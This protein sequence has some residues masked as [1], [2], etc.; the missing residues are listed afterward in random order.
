MHNIILSMPAGTPPAKL[1]AA[2]RVF[3]REQFALKHRYAMVLHTDQDHPH[4]HL[5][6]KA[7]D[8]LGERLNIRK[9]TLRAWRQE[10]ARHLVAQGVPANA[11]QRY[12][13]GNTKPTKSDGIYRAALRGES[14]HMCDRA[15]VVA[16]DL[17]KGGF[18]IEPGKIKLLKTRKD[19]ER[20]WSVVSG[21]LV[22]EGQT[23]LAAQV[24][25][26]AGQMPE[27][28]TEKE[29]LARALRRLDKDVP[30]RTLAPRL[31]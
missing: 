22:R 14:R 31:R 5:V 1:L 3:A 23:E 13:R 2:S 30:P 7:L 11:T 15:E 21:M 25:R 28:R 26:F 18:K 20:G 24:A 17:L 10:F 29:W 9:A 8:H 12:I 4:V 19:V 6:V 27:P 16:R